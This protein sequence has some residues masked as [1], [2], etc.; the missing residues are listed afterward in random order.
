LVC[1]G[2][3]IRHFWY[4]FTGVNK[5]D[6]EDLVL[7]IFSFSLL[8]FGCWVVLGVPVDTHGLLYMSIP[9]SSIVVI[10]ML[11]S[12]ELFFVVRHKK[13]LTSQ[14]DRSIDRSEEK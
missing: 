3:S 11:F 1:P 6:D 5:S 8:M 10:G 13:N 9:S 4:S 14:S 12:V 2:V 7:L